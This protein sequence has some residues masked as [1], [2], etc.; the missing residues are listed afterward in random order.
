MN[1]IGAFALFL[2]LG[3]MGAALLLGPLSSGIGTHSTR[4]DRGV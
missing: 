1:T 3:V 4:R 2:S